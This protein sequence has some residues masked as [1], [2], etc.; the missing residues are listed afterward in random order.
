MTIRV[1]EK[2]KK[3]TIAPLILCNFFRR[4]G[5]DAGGIPAY[6]EQVMRK[7]VLSEGGAA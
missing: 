2:Q 1:L 6:S 3:F 4:Y 5:L 7:A